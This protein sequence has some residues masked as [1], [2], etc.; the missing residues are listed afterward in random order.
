MASL[1]S[2][3]SELSFHDTNVSDTLSSLHDIR[4][5]IFFCEMC[6]W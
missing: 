6:K 3:R 1:S 2:S 4:A 5:L